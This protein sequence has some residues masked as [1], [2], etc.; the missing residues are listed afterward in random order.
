MAINETAI[1]ASPILGPIAQFMKAA[2]VVAGG[3]FGIYV[4]LLVLRWLEYKRFGKVLR[5][6]RDEIKE[7]NQ[8]I[9]IIQGKKTVKPEKKTKKLLDKIKRKKR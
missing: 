4:I 3:I 6:M 9:N 5:D 1:L 8:K 7:L 2:S